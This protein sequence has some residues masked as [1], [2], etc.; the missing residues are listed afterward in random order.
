MAGT[1]CTVRVMT[2]TDRARTKAP[3]DRLRRSGVL[4][5]EQGGRGGVADYTGCLVAA[6]ADQGIPVT[7][8]TAS[9]HRYRPV[10]GVRVVP[11]FAYV[12]GRS[13][14]GRLVRRLG[15]GRAANGLLFLAVM[16]RLMFIARRHALTHMQGWETPP[17]GLVAAGLLRLAGAR[18]VYTAHNTFDRKPG[19]IDSARVLP[20]LS[21]M[22]IVHTQADHDRIARPAVVIPHGQYGPVA[23]ASWPVTAAQARAELGIAPEVPV[24]LM[25]GHLRPD[26]GLDDLLEALAAVPQWHALIAG[27]DEGALAG[28]AS[29]LA[30]EQLSGRVTVREG[31]H[32]ME[33]VG[34]FFA[35]S[36]LVALPYA[37]VS[38]SGVLLLAYG[39]A[40]PVVAY[41]VGGMIEAV[42]HG[43]TG[44]ICERASP[45]AL[46]EVLRQAAGAGRERLHVLG[47]NGR[48]WAES[49]LDWDEIAQRTV[50]VYE[51]ALGAPRA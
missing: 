24:V 46:V 20:A 13:A 2:V 39:F 8:V 31:F 23:D 48:R 35:A 37:Q 49:A 50:A 19:T 21:R 18:L 5:V 41:P 28:A 9:D 40:R 7:L 16:P 44:W 26:K 33:A 10:A 17:L 38:Q 30:S 6:V 12:R 3:A 14:L 47:E 45:D 29:L 4:I 36:D 15:L 42:H 43:E 27:R 51:G 1:F 22:T 32:D 25:F 34:G 11:L